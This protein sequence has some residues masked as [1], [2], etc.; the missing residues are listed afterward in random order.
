MRYEG[1]QCDDGYA[2]LLRVSSM[3]ERLVPERNTVRGQDVQG[4]LQTRRMVLIH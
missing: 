3:A 4:N 1:A 2:Y